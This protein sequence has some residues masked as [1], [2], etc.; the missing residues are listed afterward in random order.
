MGQRRCLCRNKGVE[1]SSGYRSIDIRVINIEYHATI[2]IMKLKKSER[3]VSHPLEEF[4]EITPHTTTSDVIGV[5]PDEPIQTVAY[6]DKDLE[7]ENKLEEIYAMAIGN[8]MQ[9]ADEIEVVE[10]KFKARI[11]EVSATMLNVALGAVREKSSLKMHKDKLIPASVG[12]GSHTVNNNLVVA[13]RNE[14]LK[15]LK[16]AEDLN[17]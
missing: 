11:G 16:D 3:E 12:V 2:T 7:I 10:G 13:D 4:F 9:L 5:V 1:I 15:M 6:D 14:I 17:R 8:A